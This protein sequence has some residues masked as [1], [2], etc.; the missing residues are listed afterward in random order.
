MS[1][2]GESSIPSTSSLSVDEQTAGKVATDG[3]Q[4]DL[5]Y[6]GQV[7]KYI[8]D[9]PFTGC[10]RQS[11][12]WGIGTAVAMGLHRWR[13][14]SRFG[15]I[16]NSFFGTVCLIGLPGYYLCTNEKI[17]KRQNIEVMMK[18]SNIKP[19]EEMPEERSLDDHPFLERSGGDDDL[20]SFEKDLMIY[21]KKEGSLWEDKSGEKSKDKSSN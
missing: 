20:N 18:A 4:E 13:M 11:M 2:S 17:W 1:S 8:N 21:K 15:M 10:G 16:K 12:M 14:G 5:T 3:N 19:K 9:S 7:R 6:F